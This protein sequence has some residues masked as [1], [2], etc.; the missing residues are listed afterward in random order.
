VRRFLIAGLVHAAAF[1]PASVQPVA[2]QQSAQPASRTGLTGV[3]VD[4]QTSAPVAG[5][6]VDI[7]ERDGVVF[8][9]EAGVFR[10]PDLDAGTVTV[11]VRQ[12]GY[13]EHLTKHAVRPG[14]TLR[15]A[16]EADPVVL[17]GI[18]VLGDRFEARRRAAPFSVRAHDETA[19]AASSSYDVFGFLRERVKFTAC[20]GQPYG[21]RF[22]VSARGSVCIF[23]RG[24]WV[25]PRVFVDDAPWVGGIENLS[26]WDKRDIYRIE[27]VRGGTEVHLFTKQ[28]A[29]WLAR[30]NA[31]LQPYM[32]AR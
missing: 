30:G 4:A 2:A 31:R 7:V 8:S 23:F 27:V 22:P 1:L 19:I 14:V 17:E 18:Q 26:G 16:L 12:L 20:P 5:A 10:F 3:V 28:F 25:V 11:R 32:I 6:A 24:T 29:G 21:S 15:I 9:D 13:R